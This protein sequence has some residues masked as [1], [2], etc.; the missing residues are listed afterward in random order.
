MPFVGLVGRRNPRTVNKGLFYFT[1]M[2]LGE[3]IVSTIKTDIFKKIKELYYSDD[4]EDKE[5]AK[6]WLISIIGHPQA[7]ANLFVLS[8]YKDMDDDSDIFIDD[9]NHCQMRFKTFPVYFGKDYRYDVAFA[10]FFNGELIVSKQNE[11]SRYQVGNGEPKYNMLDLVCK[12]FRK[13]EI[14]LINDLYK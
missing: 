12:Y 10:V 3:I 7:E 5:L 13:N 9:N 1:N 8:I 2:D 11:Y 4:A 6:N 14:E